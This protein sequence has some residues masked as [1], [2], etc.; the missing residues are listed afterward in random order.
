MDW[1][2]TGEICGEGWHWGCQ[3][4]VSLLSTSTQ[5]N[6]YVASGSTPW[7]STTGLIPY[8]FPGYLLWLL[9]KLKMTVSDAS[10]LGS[11]SIFI[12]LLSLLSYSEQNWSD[13][14]GFQ[15][16]S[17]Y[18]LFIRLFSSN[19]YILVSFDV[20]NCLSLHEPFK[21]SLKYYNSD[22]LYI[23]SMSTFLLH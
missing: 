17:F 8:F 1:R 20:L 11:R 7:G 22:Y 13:M 14:N 6:T 19:A 5:W 16:T 18:L 15:L 9:W 23:I 3:R 4:Q 10:A 12:P 21:Q 2:A